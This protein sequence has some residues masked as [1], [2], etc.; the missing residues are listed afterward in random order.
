MGLTQFQV[1]GSALFM[2]GLVTSNLGNLSV[3]MGDRII[4]TRRGCSLSHL[5]E[6]D[7]IETGIFRNDRNTPLTSGEL[8]VHR[9]IYQQTPASAIIHAHLPHA[10]ALSLVMDEIVPSDDDSLKMIGRV[11]VVGFHKEIAS[12]AFADE[13]ARYLMEHKVVMVSGHGCFARGQL[14]GEAL[15]YA[16]AL[17][18]SA[19]IN[20]LLNS[21]Q[22]TPVR[23]A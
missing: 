12:G 4:I 16:T 21:M 3:R 5:E 13:I 2:Q 6:Q 9:A 11:P 23:E 1:T 10:T 22:H 19:R 18:A 20:V 15:D 14:L 7:L 8:P 17:E